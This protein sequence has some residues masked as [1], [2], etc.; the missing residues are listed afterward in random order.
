MLERWKRW[1]SLSF[2]LTK[3]EILA[4]DSFIMRFWRLSG[5]E[6]QYEGV[7]FCHVPGWEGPER[8]ERGASLVCA[9]IGAV[10]RHVNPYYQEQVLYQKYPIYDPSNP[11]VI[12]SLEHLQPR[13]CGGPCTTTS[14]RSC[15][16]IAEGKTRCFLSNS[17]LRAAPMKQPLLTFP[18][19][20]SS[21][22]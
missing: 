1:K 14:S 10:C 18:Q 22:S 5:G 6:T 4:M 21:S 16:I 17:D 3:Q 13:Y 15:C 2:L 12:C 7:A 9:V 19:T 20:C 8:L 11:F